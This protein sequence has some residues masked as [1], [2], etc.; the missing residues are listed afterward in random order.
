MVTV[1]GTVATPGL[2]ELR[3]TVT[4]P[5]G[6]GADRFS[7]SLACLVV[8][9][10]TLAAEKLSVALTCTVWLADC[11][12][13]AVAVIV[14][15]PK[16][17][18]HTYGAVLVDAVA[19]GWMKN[20][21]EAPFAGGRTTFEGSLLVSVPKTPPAPA[22]VAKVTGKGAHRPGPTVTL[23]RMIVHKGHGLRSVFLKVT[24]VMPVPIVTVTLSLPGTGVPRSGGF[25]AIVDT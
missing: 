22:G 1:A 13:D 21:V 14:A 16:L 23:E 12:P 3:F 5:T 9:I 19:P 6:A 2:S 7:V 20:V 18:P 17:T 11:K 10:V 8:V 4:P 25:T 15:D 24:S